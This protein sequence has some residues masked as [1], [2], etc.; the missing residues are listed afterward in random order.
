MH[1]YIW[2]AKL[3]TKQ[4]FP[5][6]VKQMVESTGFKRQ[7]ALDY[8]SE[9]YGYMK[10][11]TQYD[12]ICDLNNDGII[13]VHDINM[14][15]IG[16]PLINPEDLEF[17]FDLEQVKNAAITETDSKLVASFHE[18]MSKQGIDTVIRHH[19]VTAEI[20]YRLDIRAHDV[21]TDIFLVRAFASLTLNCEIEFATEKLLTASPIN[22]I[23]VAAIVKVIGYIIAGI[24]AYAIATIVVPAVIDWLK[25]M[26]TITSVVEH[27]DWVETGLTE[28]ECVSTDEISRDWIDGVC[29]EWKITKKELIRQPSF[30][31][32]GL[33][34]IFA[35]VIVLI[36]LFGSMGSSRRG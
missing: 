29:Y 4:E 6:E 1:E 36:V 2:K 23:V 18:E 28:A 17:P 16:Y 21:L 31:G 9:H 12:F 19:N 15:S 3:A 25:S 5:S 14:L 34:G 35:V 33:L 8:C 26:T 27:W 22:P 30:G 24:V 11:E 20:T 7:R 32:M 13:D 10:G